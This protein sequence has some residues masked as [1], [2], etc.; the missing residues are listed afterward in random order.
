MKRGIA[1]DFGSST[2]RFAPT[3]A[4]QDVREWPCEMAVDART[5]ERR[6]F[7][8]MARRFVEESGGSAV[9]RFPFREGMLADKELLVLTLAVCRERCGI[10]DPVNAMLSVPCHLSEEQEEELVRIAGQ[11]GFNNCYLCYSPVAALVGEG[12]SLEH[13]Y[14]TVDVGAHT[15]DIVLLSHGE[16]VYR[17]SIPTAGAAFDEA[18]MKYLRRKHRLI[19]DADVAAD[20][21]KK[22]GTL[23]VEGECSRMSAN[24]FSA[25]GTPRRTLLSSEEMFVA[26]ENPCAAILNAVHTA[27]SKIPLNAVNETFEAG[28]LLTGGGAYLGG[29]DKMITGITG[30][31]CTR[32][33]R[34]THACVLGLCT[35]Y[36]RLPEGLHVGANVSSV[37]TRT[38][39]YLD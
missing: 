35:A 7:G 16:M 12:Y 37:V 23:W 38:N 28:I 25:D 30:V 4:P 10:E 1:I 34:P 2:I 29:I 22:I 24:G 14:L 27:I 20:I 21:K 31:A 3:D 19:V 33:T 39:S 8:V 17:A 26:L 6:R 36:E 18:I 11:A 32:V 13:P 15:T 9:L 5:G